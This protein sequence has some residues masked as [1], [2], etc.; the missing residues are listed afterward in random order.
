[1]EKEHE[2]LSDAVLRARSAEFKTQLA[3]SKPIGETAGRTAGVRVR[4]KS[5]SLAARPPA[6]GSEG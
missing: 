4:L 1:V 3:G 6:K 5:A 2:S